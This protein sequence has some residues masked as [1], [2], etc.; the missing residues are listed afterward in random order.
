M[1][2]IP[3]CILKAFS[4]TDKATIAVL[5]N[6]LINSTFKVS[7]SRRTIVLQKVNSSV[8]PSPLL[9][10]DN[11]CAIF[12]FLQLQKLQ[13][14]PAPI[15]G[16]KKTHFAQDEQSDYWRAF[17]FI[18]FSTTKEII[19]KEEQA[20]SAAYSFGN[21]VKSLSNFPL[22]TIKDTIPKFHD[23]SLRFT[24]FEKSIINAPLSRIENAT[25]LIHELK[26][27]NNL[28][29]LFESFATNK[30]YKK[31]LMHHDAKL[32]N[33]LFDTTSGK[34]LTPID[35]DTT[36][37][38]YYF[39]DLGDMIRTMTCTETENSIQ[40]NSINLNSNFYNALVVGYFDAMQDEL[41]EVEKSAIH[42]SGLLIIYMQA[43]RFLADYLNGD[44][45]YKTT[46]SNQN[47]DRAKNQF[48]LLKKLEDYLF[49][50]NKI[51]DYLR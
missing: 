11:Y 51:K 25:Y 5:G 28:V 22:S 17:E 7:D 10:I 18:N 16:E 44:I 48:F 45:Y 12:N 13:K 36:Q 38:G 14:I 39:S 33:L 4:C 15:L 27:R 26:K 6:G 21:F 42:F 50:T 37:A 1:E 20:F 30:G 40:F 29:T 47:F 3:D 49:T 46:Y 8:F 41:T 31:R 2:K 34:V 23:L 32:S 19:E 24:E 9:V 43:L 35:L